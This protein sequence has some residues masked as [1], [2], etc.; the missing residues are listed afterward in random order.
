[1]PTN[2]LLGEGTRNFYS[3]NIVKCLYPYCRNFLHLP[4]P[5][6]DD[7]FILQEFFTQAAENK[8]E[9]RWISVNNYSTGFVLPPATE[10]RQEDRSPCA[11]HR[12]SDVNSD[13]VPTSISIECPT[14]KNRSSQNESYPSSSRPQCMAQRRANSA[15][16]RLPSALCGRRSLYFLC[17]SAISTLAS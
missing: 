4:C 6:A 3:I 7:E 8:L 14:P 10:L 11:D 9:L 5:V 2:S 17:Q 13:D 15:G 12:Y 1:M 16:G